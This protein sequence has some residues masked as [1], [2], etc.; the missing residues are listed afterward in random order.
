MAVQ[1][2]VVRN[3]V[4]RGWLE[5]FKIECI[6]SRSSEDEA[7]KEAEV[8]AALASRMQAE[9]ASRSHSRPGRYRQT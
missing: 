5:Q 4:C 3:W 8:D 6:S 9:A 1:Q 2:E 7:G